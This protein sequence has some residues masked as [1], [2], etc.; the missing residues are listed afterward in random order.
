MIHVDITDRDAAARIDQQTVAA[1]LAGH[2]WR[3]RARL[4]RHGAVVLSLWETA[5]QTSR[6]DVPEDPTLDDYPDV[7]LRAIRRV[8]AVEGR[9]QLDVFIDLGG[10]LGPYTPPPAHGAG[11]G[12]ARTAR[13]GG[14]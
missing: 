5:G 10:E 7:I 9:S 3:L 4:E 14:G 13:A 1:Y 12:G 8:A 6:V 11:G 2:G